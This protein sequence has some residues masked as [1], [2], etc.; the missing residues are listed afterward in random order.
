LQLNQERGS[1][2]FTEF[3]LNPR[4]KFVYM[5]TNDLRRPTHIA[6][7]KRSLIQ[8]HEPYVRYADLAVQ[9]ERPWCRWCLKIHNS[10]ACSAAGAST[11]HSLPRVVLCNWGSGVGGTWCR[12]LRVRRW[13]TSEV[14]HE[15][16]LYGAVCAEN[17]RNSA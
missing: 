16:A 14:K 17:G 3:N 12:I 7:R 5:H 4:V 13:R 11:A 8:R 10:S 2:I 15:A 6:D 9:C 1:T